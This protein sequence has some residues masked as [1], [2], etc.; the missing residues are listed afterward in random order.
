MAGLV[1]QVAR[2]LIA[3]VLS[4]LVVE[5]VVVPV[6]LVHMYVVGSVL[7]CP[8]PVQLAVMMSLGRKPFSQVKVMD[9][10]SNVV[11]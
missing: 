1:E 11:V 3:S 7:Q 9:D 6:V 4:I 10:P 2:Q 5:L 8:P